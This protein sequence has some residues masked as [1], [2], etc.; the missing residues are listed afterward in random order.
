MHSCR[1]EE[2]EAL[3]TLDEKEEP[4]RGGV[5]VC[6]SVWVP[7]NGQHLSVWEHRKSWWRL[8]T[9]FSG[10]LVQELERQAVF[11]MKERREGAR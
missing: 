8:L 6:F 11:A 9:M 2:N 10:R 3:K 1:E 5:R 4:L 7:P